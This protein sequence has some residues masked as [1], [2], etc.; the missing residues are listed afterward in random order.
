MR[1]EDV[2]VGMLVKAN[3]SPAKNEA[4]VYIGIVQN[5]VGLIVKYY[6]GDQWAYVLHKENIV[7]WNIDFIYPV[8]E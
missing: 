4:G 6:P 8:K 7:S 1:L 3:I 2:K 5:E